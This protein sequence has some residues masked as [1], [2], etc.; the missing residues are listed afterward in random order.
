MNKW[1]NRNKS[2]NNKTCKKQTTKG[3]EADSRLLTIVNSNT[4]IVFS[5]S[6]ATIFHIHLF[7][8]NSNT[9]IN[10]RP[11]TIN[12]INIINT[13]N[14]KKSSVV[15]WTTYIHSHK[16]LLLLKWKLNKMWIGRTCLCQIWCFL[17]GFV[18]FPQLLQ[19]NVFRL[20]LHV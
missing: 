1:I 18:T 7:I 17:L 5:P 19:N 20:F 3:V 16:V 4:L 11:L 8:S 15:G 10:H 2:I 9:S 12:T 14:S 6:A 13:C